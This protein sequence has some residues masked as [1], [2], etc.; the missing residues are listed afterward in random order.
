[1]W[2]EVIFVQIH[3][4]SPGDT[5]YSVARRYG[6]QPGF[7]ARQNGLYE[8]YRLA[9]GQAL[10]I[11]QVEESY[12]VRPGDTLY[13]IAR[14][15]GVTVTELWRRNP[16]LAGQARLYPGQTL[17]VRQ[18]T[19]RQRPVE[20]G[21]YAYPFVTD[22]VLE[23]ILPYASWLAPFTY[24]ITAAGGLVPLDD[25]ALLAQAKSYGVRPVLHLS[26]ITENGTFSAER[27]SALLQSEAAQVR[28]CDA[29][30]AKVQEKGYGGVDVDF[31]FLGAENAALYPQ[32]LAR[33]RRRVNE[34][35]ME[36]T[37]ALAPKTSAAQPGVLYEGHDYRA[38]GEAVDAVLLMTYEWG[39]SYGPPMAVAPLPSVRRVLDYA[40]TE[41]SP[42]KILMGFPNYGYDWTLPYAAGGE[43]AL[44]IGN[45]YAPMLAAETGAEIRYD[46]PSETP[47]FHYTAQDGVT[48]EVW[49]EDPRSTLAKYALV[50]EY[51][52]RG[53]GFWNDMRPFAAGMELLDHQFAI[54]Q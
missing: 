9:V 45:E 49:F 7:L 44:V 18:E 11:L 29:V 41:I 13:A 24:G 17:I 22:R 53:I 47:Y 6:T 54:E 16:N 46:A 36:L 14:E 21:G 8:P 51:G 42:A 10:L 37:A 40:V 23:G 39:Y 27:A 3:V 33:L 48:H 12:T 25:G 34:L 19:A 1:M 50:T 38:V 28:L 30:I 35:G 2:I 20:A 15:T 26:T 4:V 32:F 52:F 31:E 5:L 43:R